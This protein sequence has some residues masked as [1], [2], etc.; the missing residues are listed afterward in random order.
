MMERKNH[1]YVS[2][3][4]DISPQD[5]LPGALSLLQDLRKQNIR[6]ALGSASKNAQGVLER[7]GI[8]DYIDVVADGYSVERSKPAPDLFLFAAEGLGLEPQHCV[9][10]EDAASGIEAALA[11]NMWSVGLGPA[12][13]VG[14]AHIVLPNLAGLTWNDLLVRLSEVSR[15][16][17]VQR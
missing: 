1:Y 8:A 6:I 17:E 11:A 12:D 9:V 15:A 14:K 10:F 4:Q 2:F 3:I 7:L 5:L 16:L 13:R